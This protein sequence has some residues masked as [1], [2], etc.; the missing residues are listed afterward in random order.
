M[1]TWAA[2]AIGATGPTGPAALTGY[3]QVKTITDSASAQVQASAFCPAEKT[4]VGGQFIASVGNPA[5]NVGVIQAVKVLFAGPSS[6]SGYN[7]G[8]QF[9]A[10]PPAGQF[11]KLRVTAICVNLAP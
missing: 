11:N 10:V 9:D 8:V 5:P 6:A 4:V 3:E 7:A 1:K 2:G